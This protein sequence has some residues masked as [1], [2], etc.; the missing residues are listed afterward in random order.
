MTL[1]EICE[2]MAKNRRGVNFIG[3]DTKNKRPVHPIYADM[4]DIVVCLEEINGYRSWTAAFGKI[5]FRWNRVID[6]F[7]TQNPLIPVAIRDVRIP[8]VVFD[9]SAMRL[10]LYWTTDEGIFDRIIAGI[11][12]PIA[13]PSLPD[14]IYNAMDVVDG[15]YV[16]RVI[17]HKTALNTGRTNHYWRSGRLTENLTDDIIEYI[18]ET[19]YQQMFNEIVFNDKGRAELFFWVTKR[20]EVANV[21]PLE[22]P[23]GYIDTDIA[24]ARQ[25][26]ITQLILGSKCRGPEYCTKVWDFLY[27]AAKTALS[28][29][30]I[31]NVSDGY[32]TFNELYH[33]R[34]ILFA[35]L[36]NLYPDYAWKS[37]QH[38]DPD[39]PMY[40]GMFIC[41]IN[42]PNGQATY[43]YDI[44]PYWDMFDVPELPKAP[45]FDGHTPAMAIERIR[46]LDTSYAH[47]T[48]TIKFRNSFTNECDKFLLD[49]C[50]KNSEEY[51]C[52]TEFYIDGT[53]ANKDGTFTVPFRFPGAT[54]GHVTVDAKSGR[55]VEVKF[56]STAYWDKGIACYMDTINGLIVEWEGGLMPKLAEYCRMRK[57]GWV[58]ITTDGCKAR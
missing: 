17:S 40:D 34:A 51:D 46:S 53:E 1:K 49:R 39:F 30:V 28:E 21:K 18:H 9:K 32:H 5:A 41:G 35:A 10:T 7:E 8:L 16:S 19:G 4:E 15:M 57:Y 42:T 6:L 47:S 26:E 27:N 2:A 56:Y 29:G 45:K 33:H 24:S 31:G 52:H 48:C 36:C 12:N 22:I 25:A 14:N 11:I 43:H 37:K 20:A 23:M 38:D 13:T 58:E 50:R 44:D 55:V 54:R 3:K